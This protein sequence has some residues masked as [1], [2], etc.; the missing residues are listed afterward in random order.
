MRQ[1][2][3]NA[4]AISGGLSLVAQEAAHLRLAQQAGSQGALSGINTSTELADVGL[5]GPCREANKGHG[6]RRGKQL[7]EHGPGAF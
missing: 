2:H 3:A 6:H 4:G 5:A 7:F 1:S